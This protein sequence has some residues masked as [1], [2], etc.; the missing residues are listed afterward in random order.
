MLRKLFLYCLLFIGLSQL[1]SPAPGLA[2]LAQAAE[3]IR[4]RLCAPL[5]AQHAAPDQGPAARSPETSGRALRVAL[6]L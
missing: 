6:V 4:R 1:I 3:H 5:T 2:D